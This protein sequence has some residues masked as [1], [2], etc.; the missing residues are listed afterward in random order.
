MW[1]VPDLLPKSPLGP[2]Q[3]GLTG[4]LLFPNWFGEDLGSV[5]EIPVT[6]LIRDLLRGETVDGDS[7]SNSV[8]LLSA[9][10]PFSLEFATFEGGGTNAAPELRLI[11]TFS[12]RVGN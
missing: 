3:T 9:F 11:L 1:G 2:A 10:E 8:A 5:V 4:E 7:V 12:E 6:S